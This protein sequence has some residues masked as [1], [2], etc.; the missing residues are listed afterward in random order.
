MLA[1]G[2][3]SLAA[4]AV[5]A[6][7]LAGTARLWTNKGF[8]NWLLAGEKLRPRTKAFTDW[9]AAMPIMTGATVLSAHDVDVVDRMR[10]A[11]S[12]VNTGDMPSV[13]TGYDPTHERLRRGLRPGEFMGQ[14]PPTV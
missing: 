13:P 11:L 2:Q 6:A 12:E 5:G 3:G 9:V 1:G 8:L 14:V 7:A 10:D 4:A